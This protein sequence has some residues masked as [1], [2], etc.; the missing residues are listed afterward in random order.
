M[1]SK[2]R[3]ITALLLIIIATISFVSCDKATTTA[4]TTVEVT[5]SE[6]TTSE[7]T[8]QEATTT[9]PLTTTNITTVPETTTNITTT[10]EITTTREVVVYTGIEVTNQ[11]NKFF[12]ID[13]PF[14]AESF[15]LVAHLSDGSQEVVSS[16]L[17]RVRGYDSSTAGTKNL[18]V[19]FDQYIVELSVYVLEDY[20]FEIDMDYYED[21]INLKGTYLK[22]I[23]N[24]IINED[25]NPLLY[26]QARDILQESDIDPNNSSN[27]ML[28]YTGNSVSKTWDSGVTWNREHVWPQS[29]L[30][31][32][33]D[34]QDDFASRAT[35]I[36]NLKPCDPGE[37]SSRS[38]DYF[39][40]I[41]GNDFYEPRDEVKGDIARI[42]FY[43]STMYA[44]LT[45]DDD[46]T[47]PTSHY[48]MGTLSILLEWNLSDP[49]DEFE[50]NRNNVLYSYQGNRN[51]YIDYPGFADL[52]WGDLT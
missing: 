48:T 31:I 34:Y 44:I 38:N 39:N 7:Q 27:V 23:L 51:P 40:T 46:E 15:E 17:I 33:V 41:V 16:E 14:D 9:S 52:I 2:F 36:H 26:G 5:S 43:M 49:V 12:D 50:M 6:V 30:G 20:A 11:Y 19:I 35:D 25:F 21:A 24:N 42:L 47:T 8:T 4:S 22:T 32:A 28:V 3:K 13:E 37:N 1:A 10:L 29:R 45:L 18:F